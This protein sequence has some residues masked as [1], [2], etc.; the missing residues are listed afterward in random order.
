MAG[1]DTHTW[2]VTD[3]HNWTRQNGGLGTV[4]GCMRRESKVTVYEYRVHTD[5][6]AGPNF[7]LNF[8]VKVHSHTSFIGVIVS[9]SSR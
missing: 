4:Y 2:I 1:G 7:V 6:F 5:A 8:P 3:P 9:H